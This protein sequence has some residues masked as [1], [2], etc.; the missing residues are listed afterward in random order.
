[1]PAPPLLHQRSPPLL[2]ATW[3]QTAGGMLPAASGVAANGL[4]CFFQRPEVVQ[5][6]ASI[7]DGDVLLPWEAALLP[8]EPEVLRPAR[9]VLPRGREWWWQ[10]GWR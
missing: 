10:A 2:T 6:S 8:W 1:M 7:D 4:L 9:E 5:Q 3:L